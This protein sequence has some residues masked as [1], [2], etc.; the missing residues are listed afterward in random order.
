LRGERAAE[1]YI[2]YGDGSIEDIDE[3]YIGLFING[4]II[5][6]AKVL[7]VDKQFF[8]PLFKLTG[9]L[10]FQTLRA[11]YPIWQTGHSIGERSCYYKQ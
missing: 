9:P 3:E 1:S 5:K 8:A 2:Q 10:E 6:N 7:L 11:H 4:S